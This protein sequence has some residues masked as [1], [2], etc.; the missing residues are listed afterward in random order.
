MKI[1]ILNLLFVLVL[2]LNVSGDVVIAQCSGPVTDSSSCSTNYRVDQ[3]VFTS[4]S[5]QEACSAGSEAYCSDQSAGDLTVGPTYGNLYDA[6]AGFLTLDVPFLEMIVTNNTV[7]LGTLDPSTYNSAVASGGACACS[8]NVRTYRSSNYG[9]YT[10]SQPLTQESGYTLTPKSTLGVPSSDVGVEEF[11]IN[12]AANTVPAIGSSPV[13]IPDNSFADGA[14]ATGYNT[15]NQFKY[16]IGDLIAS[17]AQSAGTQAVG[18]TNYT[19]SYVA[20]SNSVTPAG[21]YVMIHDIVAV[22]TY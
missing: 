13:N 2:F 12:L 22:V 17:S 21:A 8:F 1:N 19:I 15:P 6:E 3:T 9:V 18:Q 5:A 14:A 11:G 10:M 16:A 7:D 20:K 4:G